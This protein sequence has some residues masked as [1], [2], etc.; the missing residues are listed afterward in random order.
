MQIDLT[1]R[2]TIVPGDFARVAMPAVVVT[3]EHDDVDW[4]VDPTMADTVATETSAIWFR[5]RAAWRHAWRMAR[6]LRSGR[7]LTGADFDPLPGNVRL[8][9]QLSSV[10]FIE[11]V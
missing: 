10:H 6:V 8:R 2:R 5:D 1:V 4:D 9:A 3:P 7:S 11:R